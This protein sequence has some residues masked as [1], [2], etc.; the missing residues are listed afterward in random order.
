[1]YLAKDL[2]RNRIALYDPSI[3]AALADRKQMAEELRRA[4][5]E[6]T[7]AVVYQPIFDARSMVPVAVEALV[8]W[9]H[10][11]RG[12]VRPDVFVPIAEE[13]GLIEQ[14][15][16]WVLRTACRDALGWPEVRLAVNVSPVQLRNAA[17][18]RRLTGTLAEIGFPPGRLQIEMTETHLVANPERAQTMIARLRAMGITVA[19]DDFGTGY[20]SIGYLRR[21]TFDKLKLDRSLVVGVADDPAVRRLVEA[22]VAIARA[23]RLEVTAEGVETEAEADAL[24]A[25]GC[26]QL[27]GYAFARPLSAEAAGNFLVARL[28]VPAKLSLLD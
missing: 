26:D 25:A 4:V 5:D 28:M 21:F 10:P 13:N 16:E 27:Q 14:I 11:V 12:L 18:D 23:L 24:R 3:D 8:R 9:V 22:T 20:S 2:G 17:F 1:M 15:G 7:L 19:L 6:G